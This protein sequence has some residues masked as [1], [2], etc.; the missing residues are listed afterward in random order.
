MMSDHIVSA[1]DNELMH[2]T[3]RISEMGG[4]V[5]RMVGQSVEALS[6]MDI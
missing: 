1:F 6:R 2:L 4:K 5:E 3:S